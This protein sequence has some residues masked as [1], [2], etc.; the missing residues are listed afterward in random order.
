[1]WQPAHFARPT[2]LEKRDPR[3]D[4][5]KR[6]KHMEFEKNARLEKLSLNVIDFAAQVTELTFRCKALD[7]VIPAIEYCSRSNPYNWERLQA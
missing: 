1:L 7:C 5:N 4:D 6:W 3:G 2:T